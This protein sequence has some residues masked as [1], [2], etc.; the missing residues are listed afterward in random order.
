[1]ISPAIV[2]ETQ[3]FLCGTR[4]WSGGAGRGE[5]SHHALDDRYEHQ[6]AH[7]PLEQLKGVA[8]PLVILLELLLDKDPARRFQSPAELLQMIPM[9]RDA[10]DAGRLLMKTIRVFV[11]PTGDVQKERILARKK[12]R[13][14]RILGIE[15]FG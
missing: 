3:E 13:D 12:K 14:W 1:V 9:V 5:L 11:S 4:Q 10:I 2:G 7:L 15:V 8:Q 6:H